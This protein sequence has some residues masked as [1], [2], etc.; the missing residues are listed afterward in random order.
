LIWRVEEEWEKGA[1]LHAR[2]AALCSPGAWSGRPSR[3]VRLLN[4]TDRA[5][6]L[7]SSQP[8]SDID[9]PK[10]AALGIEVGRRRTG[11][12]AVLVGPGLQRW[13]DVFLPAGDPLWE[14]DIGRAF[15]WLG[16]LWVRAL[17]EVGVEGGEVWRGGLVRTPW[18]ARVCF[19][20][21]GPGEV[22]FGGRKVVGM[23][24]RRTRHGALFQ[25]ALPIVWDPAPLL[26]VMTLS[27]L[28]RAE[29][30]AAVAD[31]AMGVGI[32]A[33]AEAVRSLVR[34]LQVGVELA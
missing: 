28:S 17:A 34:L 19:A 32:D 9:L 2:S 14:A 30:Y 11:G 22:T 8:E 27:A 31:A 13:V 5:V 3:L 33:A 10:A 1:E 21:V 4:P 15:W 26:E 12:G 24:Q 20:G 6:I 7:G 25:C 23:S 29:A 16:A 18:S